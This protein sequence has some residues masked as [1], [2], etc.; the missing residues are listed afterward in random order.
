MESFREN[1]EGEAASCQAPADSVE[2]QGWRRPWFPWA[3][4]IGLVLA[5]A[6]VSWVASYLALRPYL[7]GP[8]ADRQAPRP[9]D[10]ADRAAVGAPWLHG[11]AVPGQ[12]VTL[13]WE[14]TNTGESTWSVVDYR[15]VPEGAGLPIV[16][17]P[18][19]VRPAGVV[20]VNIWLTVPAVAGLWEPAWVLTGPEG[21][22]P[23]GRLRAT[24]RVG[25]N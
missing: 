9:K 8:P 17:L 18:R 21:Q 1:G 13:T 10:L 23:G 24:F 3:I 20:Q 25:G 16:P 22:V 19:E 2:A 11:Q 4:G 6:A 12:Q 7:G 14:L 15:L 5:G